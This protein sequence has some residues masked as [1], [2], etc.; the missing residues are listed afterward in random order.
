MVSA[1]PVVFSQADR[2]RQRDTL[3][4]AFEAK[5]QKSW[6]TNTAQRLRPSRASSFID[7]ESK[8]L[9][10][11]AV[12][13]GAPDGELNAWFKDADEEVERELFGQRN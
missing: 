11:V 1:R 10:G 8:V 9:R 3:Y 2:D 13:T 5:Y 6:R 4:F 12:G 7:K